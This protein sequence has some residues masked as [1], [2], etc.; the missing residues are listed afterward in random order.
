MYKVGNTES[1]ETTRGTVGVSLLFDI[2]DTT[3]TP[4][5]I[6]HAILQ[7]IDEVV[8]KVR[9]PYDGME[10]SDVEVDAHD[11]EM[12]DWDYEDYVNHVEDTRER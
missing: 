10:L 9:F 6:T 4:E 2:R 5:E 11:L 8:D 7:Y 12:R 1:E 3:Q